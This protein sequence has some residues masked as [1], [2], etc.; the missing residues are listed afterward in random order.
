MRLTANLRTSSASL[1]RRPPGLYRPDE[2]SERTL[3]TM[4]RYLGRLFNSPAGFI[5][6][7]PD[8]DGPGNFQILSIG[9]GRPI[10]LFSGN[11]AGQLL[12]NMNIHYANLLATGLTRRQYAGFEHRRN[13]LGRF[14]EPGITGRSCTKLL[15]KHLSPR[16]LSI[17]DHWLGQ[18]L[19]RSNC[20]RCH[21]VTLFAH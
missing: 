5:F 1:G 14:S 20:I 9:P 18:R 8:P 16:R 13:P 11:V 4:S 7:A 21:D 3:S 19:A 15:G 2:I 17:A 12:E 6:L 10:I